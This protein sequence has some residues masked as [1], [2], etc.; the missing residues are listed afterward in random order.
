MSLRL[1]GMLVAGVLFGVVLALIGLA[2]LTAP[3]APVNTNPA[4]FTT[5]VPDSDPALEG[6]RP[7][8]PPIT[9]TQVADTTTD[10]TPITDVE[11]IRPT[12]EG[13]TWRFTNEAGELVAKVNTERTDPRGPN[14]YEATDIRVTFY[15][16]G[17][18]ARLLADKGEIRG[19]RNAEPES[20]TLIG[21]VTIGVYP[22]GVTEEQAIAFEKGESDTGPQIEFTTD[23]MRFDT[24]LAQGVAPNQV[25]IRAPGVRLDG[26]GLTLRFGTSAGSNTT[27]LLL[28]RLDESD[29]LQL[30]PDRLPKSRRTRDG[31]P[32]NGADG[33]EDSDSDEPT[34]EPPTHYHFTMDERVAISRGSYAARAD[35]LEV[36]A[37]F[38]GDGLREGAIKQLRLRP[39]DTGVS[40]P[41]VGA[42]HDPFE[43]GEQGLP[44]GAPILV[45]WNGPLEL[46]PV[47]DTPP[48]LDVDDVALR[49]SSEDERGVRLGD[50]LTGTG[51]QA[52]RIT[53]FATSAFFEARAGS[54]D[55]LHLDARDLAHIETTG[56]DVDLAN[57]PD[58]RIAMPTPGI[59]TDTYNRRIEWST[60]AFLNGVMGEDRFLASELALSGNIQ[61]ESEDARA[62]SESV[63]LEFDALGRPRR[64]SLGG[65]VRASRISRPQELE[66]EFATLEL[67]PGLSSLQSVRLNQRARVRDGERTI[68]ASTI[69]ADYADDEITH[70]SALNGATIDLGNGINVL[71]ETIRSDRTRE[72]IDLVGTDT[73]PVIVTRQRDAL[74][75]RAEVGSA[76]LEEG[77]ERITGFGPGTGSLVTSGPHARYQSARL[78]WGGGFVFE[79]QTGRLDLL[80][81]VEINANKDDNETHRASAERVE[82]DIADIR[83]EARIAGVRLL[84]GPGPDGEEIRATCEARR[85]RPDPTSD[86]GR[87]LE[88][89]LAVIAGEVLIDV[90]QQT[91][92]APGAG[93]LIVEDRRNIEED[94]ETRTRGTTVFDW[95]G[96]MRV[97]LEQGI[98]SI[99]RDVRVAHR[100]RTTGDI[101]QLD[102]QRLTATLL[103]SGD[104]GTF[105][106]DRL[107]ATGAVFAGYQGLELLGDTLSFLERSQRIIVGAS[108]GNRVTIRDPDRASHYT[109]RS[110]EIDLATGN[111]RSEDATGVGGAP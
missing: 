96:S 85:T 15:K 58:V 32:S 11:Q 94:D 47:L 14:Q 12:V 46:R 8:E 26:R 67:E 77:P 38:F 110:V 27:R 25:H 108:D 4:P 69:G 79:G 9:D 35:R 73:Q 28:V 88:S 44:D 13:W 53:Y 65:G 34:A 75:L 36:F 99:E 50:D 64:V 101:T 2:Y 97:A 87:A 95:T 103:R 84:A 19:Q 71:C 60:E 105:A 37:R 72:T 23:A 82:I 81:G 33:A 16:E 29:G 30:W 10:D 61:L 42:P 89:L 93:R 111:W 3:P 22:E 18:V 104:E 74:T 24:T 102:C 7:D 78:D 70:L 86:T 55:A 76:R 91:V 20:G 59:A 92:D 6:D 48:L 43:S 83:D 17:R 57:A 109:A 41:G 90:Q 1:I 98:A 100:A 49:F 21:N 106:L 5:P 56:L 45:T 52:K 68:K 51:I 54:R 31:G 39:R 62:S 80:G 66:A 107:D 63:V 40:D